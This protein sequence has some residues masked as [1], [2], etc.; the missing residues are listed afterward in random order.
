MLAQAAKKGT[1]NFLVQDLTRD[2]AR[3]LMRNPKLAKQLAPKLS[4]MGVIA[5]YDVLKEFTK[6]HGGKYH[7]HHILEARTLRVLGM[8]EGAAPAVILSGGK[9]L[10]DLHP[11]LAREIENFEVDQLS[12]SELF[13]A[14]EKVYKKAGHPEWAEVIRP[15]FFK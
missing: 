11:K 5:R 3:H 9:H 15:Y 7:A 8:P 4:K 1:K 12:K 10:K 6:G 13:D 14:Y 2:V